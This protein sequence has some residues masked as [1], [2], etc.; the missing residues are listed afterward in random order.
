[1]FRYVYT[2]NVEFE[3]MGK[4]MKLCYAAKK[5]MLPHLVA[6]CLQYVEDNLYPSYIFKVLEFSNLLEDD[7]LKVFLTIPIIFILHI[8]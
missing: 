6:K 5:L 4:A 1:M 7:D 2:E 8:L 3:S